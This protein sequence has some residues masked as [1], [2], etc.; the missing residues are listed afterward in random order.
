[1]LFDG[2]TTLVAPWSTREYRVRPQNFIVLHRVITYNGVLTRLRIGALEEVP[3]ELEATDDARAFLTAS[4]NYSC[5]RTYALRKDQDEDLRALQ[6]PSSSPQDRVA[7]RHRRMAVLGFPLLRRRDRSFKGDRVTKPTR[8]EEVTGNARRACP[9][10]Q[11]GEPS[12]WDDVLFH[13][14]HPSGDGGKLKFCHDPWRAR[15]RRCSADPVM[16]NGEACVLHTT[17]KAGT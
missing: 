2:A 7:S 10:C 16:P 13:H 8:A 12:V 17:A 5:R 3:F 9:H 14:A 1:M 11:A 6:A 4:G 15:C